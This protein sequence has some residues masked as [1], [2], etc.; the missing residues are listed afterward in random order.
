MLLLPDNLET[1][2]PTESPDNNTAP[3]ST[4][5][6]ATNPEL[7]Q[8][9]A[10]VCD[11]GIT[12]PNEPFWV[13]KN[14]TDNKLQFTPTINQNATTNMEIARNSVNEIKELYRIKQYSVLLDLDFMY[15]LSYDKDNKQIRQTFFGSRLSTIR[16]PLP[17]E[18]RT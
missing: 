10:D 14:I 4:Q 16:N 13:K 9:L 5:N 2:G 11:I 18:E 12:P 3:I 1:R 15:T 6:T 17:Q 7:I 8:F